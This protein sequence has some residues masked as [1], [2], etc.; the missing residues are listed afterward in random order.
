MNHTGISR[1]GLLAASAAGMLSAASWAK[2]PERAALRPFRIY[3]VTFRGMT[4]VEKGFEEY[5]ASRKIPVQIV[6]RDLNRD[7]TRLAAFIQE[8]RATR[9]DLVYTWGTSV[10]L[11][12]VGAQDEVDRSAFI[13]DIPVVFTMVASPVLAK[14]V[15]DTKSSLRNVTGVAHVA[16]TQAQIQ[17]M[18]AYRPFQSLGVLYTPT[19]RNSVV[20]VEEIRTLGHTRGFT[21]VERFAAALAA[22]EERLGTRAQ[23]PCARGME[24]ERVGVGHGRFSFSHGVF[25]GVAES[26]TEASPL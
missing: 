15:P 17:A 5:F 21:T 3:A 12:I 18:S 14:I 25:S 16:S 9:P 2:A 22:V 19:E 10:T 13:N 7:A 23:F 1:R 11:G 26:C 8:I 24:H 20:V 6:Y 4:D